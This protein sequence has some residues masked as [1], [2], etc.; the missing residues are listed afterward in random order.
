MVSFGPVHDER[1]NFISLPQSILLQKK[2]F[3]GRQAFRR[4][5]LATIG[6]QW[7]PKAKMM[8]RANVFLSAV[9]NIS[10]G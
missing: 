7:N 8:P 2:R 3:V 9:A 1:A 4:S 5:S 6:L 10:F